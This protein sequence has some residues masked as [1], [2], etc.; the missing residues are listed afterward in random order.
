MRKHVLAAALLAA[1]AGCQ[2]PADAPG[3]AP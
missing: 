2:K 3:V 1:L